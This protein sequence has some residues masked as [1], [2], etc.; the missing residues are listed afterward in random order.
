MSSE[1]EIRIA[2]Q[3]EGDHRQAVAGEALPDQLPVRP[4]RGEVDLVDQ[5]RRR[6]GSLVVWVASILAPLVLDPRVDDR[7]VG[8]RRGRL[9]TM[10]MAPPIITKAS[11]TGSRARRPRDAEAAEAGQVKTASVI[12]APP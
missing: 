4:D 8:R 10:T 9:P 1:A 2:I 11:T 12:A 3:E 7:V 6:P 5:L